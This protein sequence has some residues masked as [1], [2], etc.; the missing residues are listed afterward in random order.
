MGLVLSILASCLHVVILPYLDMTLMACNASA[1]ILFAVLLS[2]FVLGEAFI[3]KY[4]CTALVLIVL[5][6][7]FIVLNANTEQ[8]KYTAD[9]AADILTSPAALG[10]GG[11]CL[12]FLLLSLYCL[13]IFLEALR[14]FEGSADAYDCQ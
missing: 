12:F 13:K 11:F 5:G 2:M 9:E 10:F 4:D 3:W 1:A 8:V 7:T 6:C 14:T